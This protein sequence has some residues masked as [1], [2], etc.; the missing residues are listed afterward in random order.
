MKRRKRKSFEELVQEN[1][2]LIENDQSAMEKIEER[3]FERLNALKA[4]S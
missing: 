2:M 1:R 4:R 3:V